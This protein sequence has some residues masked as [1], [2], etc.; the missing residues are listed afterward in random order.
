MRAVPRLRLPLA[1]AVGLIVFACLL[2]SA[3]ADSSG[4]T[5]PYLDPSYASKLL[6]VVQDQAVWQ[7]AENG[8][9]QGI[10]NVL[11]DARLAALKAGLTDPKTINGGQLTVK[12]DTEDSWSWAVADASQSDYPVYA[13]TMG[14]GLGTVAPFTTGHDL[15]GSAYWQYDPNG[16]LGL[17]T[18]TPPSFQWSGANFTATVNGGNPIWALTFRGTDDS[19]WYDGFT[20][21]LLFGG[22]GDYGISQATW[23]T[24]SER[25]QAMDRGMV[26]SWPS[27]YW[28]DTPNTYVWFGPYP[29]VSSGGQFAC[30]PGGWSG[31]L[32]PP[33]TWYARWMDG[34][35]IPNDPVAVSSARPYAELDN[36]DYSATQVTALNWDLDAARTAIGSDLETT[37]WVNCEL[38]QGPTATDCTAPPATLTVATDSDEVSVADTVTANLTLSDPS[39]A[40][41]QPATVTVQGADDLQQDVLL[42]SDGTA[43]FSYYASAEGTDTITAT[44]GRFN[45]MRPQ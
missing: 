10:Q 3:S 45:P 5:A 37:G 11:G 24:I 32:P 20:A 26:S 44:L 25:L 16:H 21:S 12:T 17:Y 42:G 30:D 18:G 19:S 39:L 34:S 33:P 27:N 35:A 28:C 14:T 43:T 2:S 1:I 22:L 15:S 29:S 9:P 40:N 6:Q 41:G 31:T 36:P 8:A 7:D 23:D 4:A 38:T 13:I